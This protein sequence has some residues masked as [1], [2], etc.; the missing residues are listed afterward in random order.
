MMVLTSPRICVLGSPPPAPGS[1]PGEG[2]AF[3]SGG[4]SAG[5]AN[6][7]SLEVGGLG[8]HGLFAAITLSHDLHIRFQLQTTGSAADFLAAA[9]R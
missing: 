7:E 6:S 2:A 5:E 9:L 4:G 1:P 3:G 8:G